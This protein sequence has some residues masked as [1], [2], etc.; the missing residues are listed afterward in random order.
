[1]E[2]KLVIGVL[3]S[4]LNQ[5]HQVTSVNDSVGHIEA[6]HQVVKATSSKTTTTFELPFQ[7]MR[8]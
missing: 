4:P 3:C 8:A 2:E 6:R 7:Q 5:G 1:M